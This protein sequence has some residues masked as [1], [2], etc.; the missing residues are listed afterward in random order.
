MGAPA[1]VNLRIGDTCP[2]SV[3]EAGRDQRARTRKRSSSRDLDRRES[4][5]ARAGSDRSSKPTESCTARAVAQADLLTSQM[6]RIEAPA[7]DPQVV[8]Q[9]FPEDAYARCGQESNYLGSRRQ[10][11]RKLLR[12]DLG[13]RERGIAE[14]HAF[15]PPSTRWAPSPVRSRRRGQ[16][17]K[18]A[19]PHWPPRKR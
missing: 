18:P 4:L 7:A 16:T 9:V 11:R 1:V 6:L 14:D 19:V 13:L 3:A 8:R 17:R 12:T 15:V 5:Y 2:E 10:T